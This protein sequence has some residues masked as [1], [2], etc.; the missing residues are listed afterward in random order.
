MNN[1][2]KNGRLD[3]ISFIF[4]EVDAQE[5]LRKYWNGRKNVDIMTGNRKRRQLFHALLEEKSLRT[6][7]TNTNLLS[8]LLQKKECKLVRK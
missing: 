8:I 1:L 4:N 5:L 2:I 7:M 6:S 3:V